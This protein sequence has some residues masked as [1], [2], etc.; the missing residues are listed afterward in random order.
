MSVPSTAL[1]CLP[2]WP[3]IGPLITCTSWTGD[4]ACL[5]LFCRDDWRKAKVGITLNSPTTRT[6]R[7]YGHTFRLEDVALGTPQSVYDAEHWIHRKTGGYHREWGTAIAMKT[8]YDAARDTFGLDRPLLWD[9][10]LKQNIR[11][12]DNVPTRPHQPRL[13]I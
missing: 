13:L 5:Y 12:S 3:G 10:E 2:S 11:K 7:E 1:F 9:R 8:L 4:R 6:P